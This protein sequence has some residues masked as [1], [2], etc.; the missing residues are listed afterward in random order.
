MRNLFM[1]AAFGAL[2]AACGGDRASELPL[3]QQYPGGWSEGS[4]PAINIALAKAGASGCGSFY[5]KRSV[6]RDNEALVYC[7]ADGRTWTSWLV[8]MSPDDPRQSNAVGPF[9]PDP[10]IA[11][12]A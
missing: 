8:I 7:T 3:S 2:A 6:T 10:S 9:R 5:F 12:P 4:M 1:V 11:P